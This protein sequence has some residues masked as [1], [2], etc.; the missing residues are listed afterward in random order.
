MNKKF[1]LVGSPL[2][3]DVRNSSKVL[4]ESKAHQLFK[5]NNDRPSKS[6]ETQTFQTE[7][8]QAEIELISQPHPEKKQINEQ[9]PINQQNEESTDEGLLDL[10][11]RLTK[12][13]NSKTIYM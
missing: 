12:N 8:P 13:N 11:R 3:R 5:S 4:S 9:S 10:E 2:R 1:S 6:S 7:K